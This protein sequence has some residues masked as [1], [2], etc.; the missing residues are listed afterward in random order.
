MDA[1]A[2]DLHTA[3]RACTAIDAWAARGPCLAGVEALQAAGQL[4]QLRGLPVVERLRAAQ[5]FHDAKATHR[6]V[7]PRSAA[8]KRAASRGVSS[9][10]R[11]GGA[12]AW[13]KV[14]GAV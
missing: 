6:R 12:A 13:D 11:Q 8:E 10:R 4:V 5:R 9:T 3:A 14:C 7:H 1:A 2:H